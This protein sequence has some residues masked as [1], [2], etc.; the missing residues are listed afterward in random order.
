MRSILQIPLVIV[1]ILLIIVT[2]GCNM[3]KT[4]TPA[5]VTAVIQTTEGSMTAELYPD[6][7]PETVKNF[8]TL[9]EQGKYDGVPFH[10]VIAD[11]MI[12]TGDFENQ[13][14]TGGH[15][16]KGPG[17]MFKDEFDPSL[18]HEYGSLSMAN[19]GPNTNGSQFFIVHAED[20]TPFLDGKHSV[21]GK[22]TNGQDVLE[23]IATTETE[24]P[25]RP[26]EEIL[27]ETITFK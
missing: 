3:N 18:S 20:G 15:S 12:Q 19:R 8:M 26:V 24:G 4:E 21:F 25:D 7:A 10:R 22:L 11:F 23:S 17:T 13:N 2:T 9:A 6:K 27:I 1:V 16:Y 14:G 5:E